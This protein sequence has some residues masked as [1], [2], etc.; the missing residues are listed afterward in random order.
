MTLVLAS[1]SPF[2]IALLKQMGYIPDIVDSPDIDETG[3]KGEKPLK[4]ATRLASQKASIVFER[5]SNCIVLGADTVTTVGGRILPKAL[6]QEEAVLC[7]NAW[8][9]KRVKVYTGVCCIKAGIKREKNSCTTLKF[10]PLS[11]REKNAYLASREWYGKAGGYGIQ[12]IAASFISWSSGSTYTNV[13]G[14]PLYETYCLLS[15]FGVFPN[16]NI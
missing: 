12:G 4:L 14:L 16:Y 3:F 13:A 10:K 15:S 9:G 8:S 6:T 7:M 2:R 1:S 11:M 5:H